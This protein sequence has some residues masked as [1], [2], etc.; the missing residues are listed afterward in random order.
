MHQQWRVATHNQGKIKEIRQLLAASNI[1][2]RGFENSDIPPAEETGL[3]FIENAILKARHGCVHTQQPC[4]ADDS[5]L[6]VPALGGEP[7]I[8]SARYGGEHLGFDEKMALLLE[9]LEEKKITNARAFFY[10]AVASLEHAAD[11]QPVVVTASWQGHIAPK[12]CGEAG[13]GYDPI[14]YIETLGCTAAQLDPAKKCSIS[15]RAQA[16]NRWLRCLPQ[17]AKIKLNHE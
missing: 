3:S 8:Y 17:A 16:I 10:C 13:F 1:E 2:V 11:E 6:C 4:L 9:R 14:F 12:P 15:H 5:G 7:G